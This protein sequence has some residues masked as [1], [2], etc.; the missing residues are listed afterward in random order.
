MR[1]RACIN[2]L[3]EVTRQ[4]LYI[5]T[6]SARASISPG[7]YV[8]NKHQVIHQ[9]FFIQESIWNPDTKKPQSFSPGTLLLLAKLPSIDKMHTP[10]GNR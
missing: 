8:K 6:V 7:G 4:R 5:D 3:W 1:L 10:T 9:E 2:R